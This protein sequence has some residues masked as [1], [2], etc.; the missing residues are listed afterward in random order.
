MKMMHKLVLG[1]ACAGALYGLWQ[2]IQAPQV[3][4]VHLSLGRPHIVLVRHFPLT[5]Q[6][7]IDWWD[8][9]Q[10]M[11]MTKY[12]IPADDFDLTFMEW[13]GNYLKPSYDP[14]SFFNIGT[15]LRCFDDMDAPANCVE[16]NWPMHVSR[17]NDGGVQFTV[18][19]PTGQS[20]YVREPGSNTLRLRPD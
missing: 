13:D 1:T 18:E 16:K 11:L 2:V 9:N 20:T 4:A 5:Q 6:G 17:R 7:K 15:E 12:K 14:S 19:G 10:A 3:D 8:R